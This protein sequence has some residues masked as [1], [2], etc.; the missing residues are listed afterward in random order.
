[1]KTK[2]KDKPNGSIISRSE[3]WAGLRLVR[4]ILDGIVEQ[5]DASEQVVARALE[6]L[7]YLEKLERQGHVQMNA[8]DDAL[9]EVAILSGVVPTLRNA[10][11][12][13]SLSPGMI[14]SPKDLK[15]AILFGLFHKTSLH[16]KPH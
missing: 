3:C 2:R 7:E 16:A 11:H 13:T 4:H 1:M 14:M 9:L 12:P 5:G 8:E 15:E 6:F 10:P